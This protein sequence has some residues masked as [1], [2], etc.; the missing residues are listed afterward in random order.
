[1]AQENLPDVS[2][3]QRVRAHN[4]PDQAFGAIRVFDLPLNRVNPVGVS[5][6]L[7]APVSIPGHI[8]CRQLLTSLNVVDSTTPERK[9]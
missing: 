7:S 1:M 5:T 3:E 8:V 9:E 2:R 4:R 6:V